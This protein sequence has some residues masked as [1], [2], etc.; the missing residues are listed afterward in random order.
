M[1]T[2]TKQII[3]TI[4]GAVVVATSSLISAFA[5]SVAPAFIAISGAVNEALNIIL[6]QFVNDKE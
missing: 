2:K 3:T 4:I 1:T 6:Q 5:P